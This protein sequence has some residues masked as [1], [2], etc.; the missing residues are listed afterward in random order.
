MILQV[1]NRLL[2][3]A[4]A[5]PSITRNGS[6]IMF[7]KI[8]RTKTVCPTLLLESYA[9]L[10]HGN[11][12]KENSFPHTV[13]DWYVRLIHKNS[14]K[15]MV[16]PTLLLNGTY[17]SFTE[18][19]KRK[20]FAPHCSWRISLCTD[21]AQPQNYITQETACHVINQG[22]SEWVVPCGYFRTAVDPKSSSNRSKLYWLISR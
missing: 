19:Y 20:R 13:C 3:R 10:V 11:L 4:W 17:I 18:I 7:T 21:F 5:S 14:R 15:K 6:C 16:F 8:Y 12:L 2:G 1:L 22:D 9:R